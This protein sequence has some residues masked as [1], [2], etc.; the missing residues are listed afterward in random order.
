MGEG[1]EK[2]RKSVTYYLNEPLLSCKW[3]IY[4][5]EENGVKGSDIYIYLYFYKKSLNRFS[6]IY[7]D[8][9]A[10]ILYDCNWSMGVRTNGQD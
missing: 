2:G 10:L 3:L 1:S 8:F 4:T 9:E 7:Y 6:L 5:V